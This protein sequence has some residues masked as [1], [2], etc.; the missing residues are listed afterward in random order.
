[1]PERE[2]APRLHELTWK[3]AAEWFRRDPRLLLPVGT[4][5]QHGPHLPLG[6][7]TLIVEA[8]AE[9]VAARHGVLLA[10]TLAYGGSSEREQ[11]YAGTA[12]LR[13]KT[14]HRVLNELVAQWEEQGVREFILMTAQGYGPHL[15]ALL[16]VIAERA[17]VRAVD[18]NAVDV[19]RFLSA[20]EGPEHA[21][22]FETS[23]LL[24][25]APDRVRRREIRDPDEPEASDGRRPAGSEAVPPEGSAGVVGKPTAATAEKGRRIYAHLVDHI[26]ARLFGLTESEMGR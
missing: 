14:L 2:S 17:R 18:L 12:S 10:P 21:A 25:L 23:L 5:L 11:A 7:D 6:V 15:S 24:H 22:E 4:C 16:A 8:V 26:G 3:E 13:V 1:M 20:R 9:A 19:S